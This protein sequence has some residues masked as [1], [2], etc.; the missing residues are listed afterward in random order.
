M[1]AAIYYEH[2]HQIDLGT[3]FHLVS[4]AGRYRDLWALHASHI[5]GVVFVVDVTDRARIGVAREELHRILGSRGE[6]KTKMSTLLLHSFVG[7]STAR[8]LVHTTLPQD[9]Y[10]CWRLITTR[11]L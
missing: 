5:H 3:I 1:Y 8:K 4:L 10:T 6:L 2:V 9:E 7:L 11:K